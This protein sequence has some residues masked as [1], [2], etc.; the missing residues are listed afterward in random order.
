M[1]YLFI[2][3]LFLTACQKEEVKKEYSVQLSISGKSECVWWY[4][5]QEK[6]G[7]VA[8]KFHSGDT[9]KLLLFY[10]GGGSTPTPYCMLYVDNKVVWEG[11]NPKNPQLYIFK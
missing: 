7:F 10:Q 4:R 9:S 2:I 8:H 11:Q 3:A 5:N 6:I 1:K